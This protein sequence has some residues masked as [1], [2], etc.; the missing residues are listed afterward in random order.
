MFKSYSFFLLGNRYIVIKESMWT[1]EM[2]K[3]LDEEFRSLGKHECCF[4]IF[5]IVFD[6][7]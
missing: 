4:L 6:L 1:D 7:D 2:A 5:M 3:I